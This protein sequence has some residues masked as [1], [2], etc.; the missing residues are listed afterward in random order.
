MTTQRRTFARTPRKEKVWATENEQAAAIILT[1]NTIQNV[2]N[3]LSAFDID[4]GVN[5]STGVTAMRII[6][7]FILGNGSS[8]SVARVSCAIWGIAWVRSA[9]STLSA[10]DASIPDPAKTGVRDTEWIQRGNLFTTTTAGVEGYR[11]GDNHNAIEL[12]ITQQRKQPTVDH[13]LMLIIKT[14]NTGG[15]TSAP[16]LWLWTSVMCALP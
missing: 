14:Q 11:V 8:E 1:P 4:L 9:V 13:K 10:G 12:D 16:L 15:G 2:R 6:G 5:R 7:K 3:L